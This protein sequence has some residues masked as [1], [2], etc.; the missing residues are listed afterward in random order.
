MKPINKLLIFSIIFLIAIVAMTA[1]A[2]KS[3]RGNDE[4]YKRAIEVYLRYYPFEGD[5]SY[6]EFD[7][8]FGHQ[9][10]EF[11][12]IE[13]AKQRKPLKDE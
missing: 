4:D 9:D 11:Y 3:H 10:D 7:N 8:I 1:A 2:P 6:D 12:E 13:N 5:A